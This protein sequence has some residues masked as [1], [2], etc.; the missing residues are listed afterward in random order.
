MNTGS[1]RRCAAIVGVSLLAANAAVAQEFPQ[2]PV[3]MVVPFAPG[4]GTDVTA[5]LVAGRL[6][7]R[8]GQPVLVDNRPANSGIVGAEIVARAVPDGHTLLV[9]SVTFAISTAL[10][11]NL[12]Y[13]GLRDFA[14]VT[15]LISA[16]MGLLVHPSAPAKTTAEFIAWAKREPGRL[17]YGSSGAGSIAHLATEHFSAM[18]GIRMTHVPY[19][20]VAAFTAAQLG[21]EIQLGMGN[22][23]STQ[24]LWKSGRLRLI[25]HTGARRLDALPDVPTVAESGLPGF[26]AA[27]WYGF[28][29]PGRTPATRVARLQR[30]IAAIARAPDVQSQLVAQGND[31]VASTPADFSR[32][33]REEV[34]RWGELGRT[35]GV[36]L[37]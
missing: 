11:K 31:V 18:A 12:P 32:S 33:M 34:R 3:R 13:D 6:S 5:R 29:A 20:G 25:A 19:K 15:M 21:N 2:R 30:E 9:A 24:S 1:M 7:E 8:I 17:N 35:L 28:L 22:L 36:R 4:G 16:P 26:E 10:Q 27:I 23:F 14:P 37:D